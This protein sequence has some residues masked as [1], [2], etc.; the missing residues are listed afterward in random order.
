MEKSM[1]NEQNAQEK[2]NEEKPSEEGQENKVQLQFI[3]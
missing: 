3:M 2:L 1:N